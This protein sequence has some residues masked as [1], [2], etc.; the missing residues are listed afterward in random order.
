[1]IFSPDKFQPVIMN[2]IRE[3][4][5]T[6]KLKINNN[7]IDTTKSIKLLGIEIDNQLS[8]NQHISKLNRYR[9]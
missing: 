7:E 6:H 8:F 5:I 4:Q 3:N 9:D 2:K 1:M